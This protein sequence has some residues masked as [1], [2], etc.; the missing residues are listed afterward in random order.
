MVRLE[1]GRVQ[2]LRVFEFLHRLGVATEV[3]IHEGEAVHTVGQRRM[4]LAAGGLRIENSA[5]FIGLV[6]HMFG[7]QIVMLEKTQSR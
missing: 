3:K 2:F 4:C 6:C 7:L 1:D 5:H